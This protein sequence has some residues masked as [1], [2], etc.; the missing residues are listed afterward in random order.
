MTETP[1][2]AGKP[3]RR[4]AVTVGSATVDIITV[5]A[6]RDIERVT[7]TN[8]TASFLLLEQ[9]RK[10]EAESITIHP[11]GGA[12]NTAVC[13]SRLGFEVAPIVKVGEDLNAGQILETLETERLSQ[14]LVRRSTDLETGITVMISSH[15]RNAT[16]F[17]FRGA[18]TSIT[19][20]DLPE[21]AFEGADLVHVSG[22]SNQSADQFAHI[23]GA[24]RRAGAFVSVNPGIRQLTSRREAFLS[25][26]GDIDLLN[27]NRVE[28]EALMPALAARAGDAPVPVLPDDAPQLM[29]RGLSASGFDLS[30]EGF[31]AALH[32]RGVRI[33]SVTDGTDGAYLSMDGGLF[34]CPPLEVE[35]AARERPCGAF[36]SMRRSPYRSPRPGTAP[37]SGGAFRPN[38][39]RAAGTGP[40]ASTPRRWSFTTAG[41][42][43]RML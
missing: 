24:A 5:I 25:V 2:I 14:A 26:A 8:V 13:L 18:N 43:R 31:C 38:S 11:G 40:R 4:R 10:M 23:V 6:D 12:L 29:R 34:F 9:G 28:A 35:P 37:G 22:L 17:T 21:S 27:I 20:E 19:A 30:L 33:V 36:F 1:D 41:R 3:V 39:T 32:E 16:I 42:F 7:M 15:D